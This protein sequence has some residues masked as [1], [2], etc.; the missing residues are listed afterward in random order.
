MRYIFKFPD[1][2]EGISEG[3]ILKWY[4]QKGQNIKSQDPVVKMETDKVVTDIPSPKDGVVVALFGKEGEVIN[5]DDPLLEIEI[6]GIEGE[7]A[8]QVAREKPEPSSKESVGEKGF[9]VVGTLEV[10]GD[11]AYLPS[12]QEGMTIPETAVPMRKA[13]ATPVA[14]AMAKELG[15]DINRVP[16]TGPGDRV[17]KKDI[18]LFHDNVLSGDTSGDKIGDIESLRVEYRP[19]T[20]LR[21]TIARNM[22]QSKH[23]AAHMTIFE[24]VE[25]SQLMKLRDSQKERFSREGMKLTY[26]AFVLKAVAS[27]LREFPLLNSEMDLENDRLVLKNILTLGLLLTRMTGWWYR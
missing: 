4:V 10:A 21:K 22:I 1:I 26:L 13:L 20:Q 14:R 23:S 18:Q 9:G 2:G 24:E 15:L 8:Q 11:A 6:E 3:K 5:V 19:L 27:A 17:M 12:S 16:G 25:I 7:E